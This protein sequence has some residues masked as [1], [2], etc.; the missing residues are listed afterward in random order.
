MKQLSKGL[1]VAASVFCFLLSTNQI[2]AQKIQKDSAKNKEIDEVVSTV[3]KLENP[4]SEA[5][6][7]LIMPRRIATLQKI[8]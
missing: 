6:V 3:L 4:F 7:F 2:N 5:G 8:I 1:P